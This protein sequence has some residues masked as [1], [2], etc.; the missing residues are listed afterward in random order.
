MNSL[1][2]CPNRMS[3]REHQQS[4]STDTSS[5]TDATVV[6]ATKNSVR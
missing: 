4:K 5:T 2:E 1:A 6:M 3:G